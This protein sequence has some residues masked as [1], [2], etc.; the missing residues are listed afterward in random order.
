MGAMVSPSFRNTFLV[1][2][3]SV[4][5]V[6]LAACGTDI[7]PTVGGAPASAPA[8]ALNGE[9]PAVPYTDARFHYSIDAPGR[10]TAN[11][12][13]TASFIGPSYRLEISVTTGSQAA[14]PTTLAKM[15]LAAL[16]SSAS[17]FHNLADPGRVNINGRSV[18][19]FAYT[20]V[21]G[22]SQVTG[23]AVDLTTARY[24]IPKDSGTLAV[25]TY[26]IVSNQFDPQGAD[27]LALTFRWQ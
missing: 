25:V 2:A 20:W 10:M 19:R 26:G 15:D 14:D 24:Y 9:A 11:P 16:A 12:D 21:A 17:G 23:K 18:V 22:T 27:D 13:G 5:A 7:T 1:A 4:G 3:L 8:E 6:A